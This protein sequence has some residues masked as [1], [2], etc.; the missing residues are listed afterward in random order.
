MD[1]NGVGWIAAI[2]IGG[3]AGWLAEMFM[4]SNMGILMN[5]VLGIV[6]AIVLN[7][8]LQALNIGAFGTGWIAY[9]ITGFVG[10]CLLIL[11]GRMVRR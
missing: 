2:I 3:L 9:L 11:A 1:V 5:I 4:K 10:A 8:I 7:A 6:G